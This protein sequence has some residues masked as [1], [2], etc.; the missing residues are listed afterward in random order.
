MDGAFHPEKPWYKKKWGAGLL[1]FLV[2][3]L[4]AVGGFVYT[5]YKYYKM[6]KR[7]ETVTLEGPWTRQFTSGPSTKNT[8]TSIN[9]EDLEKTAYPVLGLKNAP[10]TIV[11]FSDYKCPNSKAVYPILKQLAGKYGNKVK[12]ITRDFPVFDGSTRY[13]VLARCANE[14]KR[15][16]KAHDY[17][18][19]HQE[20]LVEPIPDEV[21]TGVSSYASLNEEEL[22]NC[23]NSSKFENSVNDDFFYGVG[24]GVRGTPTFFVNGT[25]IEGV[26]PFDIWEKYINSVIP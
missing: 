26:V 18:Y 1:T 14:Q 20:L 11:E 6:I 19:E 5:T 16:L 2:I 22:R 3:F 24:A 4:L 12:I 7:G 25:K 9:L 8:L 13:A 15:F 21:I 10:I 17:L 23:L